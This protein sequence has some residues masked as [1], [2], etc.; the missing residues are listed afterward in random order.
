MFRFKKESRTDA[1]SR[2]ENRIR[3][4]VRARQLRILHSP[5]GKTRSIRRSYRPGTRRFLSPR[6]HT[7][8]ERRRGYPPASL[9]R[10]VRKCFGTYA[11]ETHCIDRETINT[12]RAWFGCFPQAFSE[13]SVRSIARNFTFEYIVSV[14]I[15]RYTC[16]P[17]IEDKNNCAYDAVVL[18]NVREYAY[19]RILHDSLGCLT[20]IFVSLCI[21]V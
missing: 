4:A 14:D 19:T 18:G 9:T 2:R 15:L 1:V 20:R 6:L 21:F 16:E 8:D 11:I 5:T 17:D 13:Q 12:G 7:Q 3:A 10:N